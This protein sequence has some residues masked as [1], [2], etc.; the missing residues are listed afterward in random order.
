LALVGQELLEHH[1]TEVIQ[2]LRRLHRMVAAMVAE[3]F[4][5]IQVAVVLAAVEQGMTS[6]ELEMVAQGHLVRDM[7]E[8]MPLGKLVAAV[9][10]V[11]LAVVVGH[12]LGVM[13][14]AEFHHQLLGQRLRAVAVAVG[15]AVT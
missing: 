5:K 2:F 14:E 8:A 15:Q 4:L 10:L 13:A 1:Q 9:V 7:Q 12:R 11:E 6:V 3:T